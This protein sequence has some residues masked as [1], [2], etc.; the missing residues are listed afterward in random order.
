M[1]FRTSLRLLLT[2]LLLVA[3]PNVLGQAPFAT[4]PDA[5]GVDG[6]VG[7][8]PLAP[9]NSALDGLA[10]YEFDVFQNGAFFERQTST[11]EYDAQGRLVRETA[12]TSDPGAEDPNRFQTRVDFAYAPNGLLATR[13]VSDDLSGAFVPS[14]R[15]SYTYDGLRI[16]TI[17]TETFTDGAFVPTN[18]ETYEYDGT[19]LSRITVDEATEGALAPTGRT[20]FTYDGTATLTQIVEE[21]AVMGGFENAERTTYSESGAELVVLQERWDGSSWTNASRTTYGD[22]TVDDLQASVNA[23]GQFSPFDDATPLS[24]IAWAALF[25]DTTV[26][27]RF[28]S[29]LFAEE[30]DGT[31]WVPRSRAAATREAGRLVGVL[32]ESW[33]DGAWQNFSREGYTYAPDGQVSVFISE[34]WASNEDGS[35]AWG[36]AVEYSLT[37]GPDVRMSEVVVSTRTSASGSFQTLDRTRFAWANAVS[38]EEDAL[39]TGASL[40]LAGPNP[41]AE[42]TA[43]TFALEAPTE[44]SVVVYDVL[45][46]AVATLA[47]ETFAAGL[48]R[49]E[50]VA[51][52]LPAG[53]YAVQLVAGD[54]AAVA[55]VTLS[56]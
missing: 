44:A 36:A 9:A 24:F 42:R 11:R 20:T 28:F 41:F 48:H 43:F 21:V 3:S 47:D 13:I 2:A 29:T 27:T 46:R 25:E 22:A 1:L 49:I 55:K 33:E 32:R 39:T 51:G 6:P 31:A 35:G 56:R 19:L 5:L 18:R 12:T 7:L 10:S 26:R 34:A 4:V 8:A 45:G 37:Y 17:T 16:S 40:S 53:V 50:F 54:Q 52:T 14:E 23:L 30:W 15:L 38:T